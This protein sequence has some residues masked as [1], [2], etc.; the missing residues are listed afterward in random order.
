MLSNKY[1]LSLILSCGFVSAFAAQPVASSAVAAASA[2]PKPPKIESVPILVEQLDLR[3]SMPNAL[4]FNLGESKINPQFVPILSWN[5]TYLKAFPNAKIEVSGNADDYSSA[6]KNDA[7]S[8][9]RAN[10]VRSALLDLGVPDQQIE[11]YALGDRREVFKKDSDGHQPRNQRVDIFYQRYAPKGYHVEKVPV[12]IT[13][14]Y[15]QAV[16][17]EP[18]Q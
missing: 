18:V 14:T 11:V 4:V 9:Q 12:V 5:A 10:N 3:Q 17:P 13:D 2:M 16:I 15:E 6:A 7:L 1:L 8:L